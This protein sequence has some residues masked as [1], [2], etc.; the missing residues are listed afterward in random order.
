M[1]TQSTLSLEDIKS[2][3]CVKEFTIAVVE[4]LEDCWKE[5]SVYLICVI[6]KLGLRS[7]NVVA[8]RQI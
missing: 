3:V 1:N 5:E 8:G 2:M 7:V 4:Y 6:A